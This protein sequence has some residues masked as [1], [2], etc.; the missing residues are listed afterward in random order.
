MSY[1]PQPQADR[2]R[3][4]IL[5]SR[6]GFALIDI[7][8]PGWDLVDLRA[9]MTVDTQQLRLLVV[10]KD[11]REA[12]LSELNEDVQRRVIEP[13]AELRRLHYR[14]DAGTWFSMR[15]SVREDSYSVAYDFHHEPP[16]EPPLE[17]QAYLR[18]FEAYRRDVM[19]LPV[20]LRDKLREAQPGGFAGTFATS[21]HMSVEDQREWADEAASLLSMNLP[22]GNHQTT[23]Y[24]H[25][26]GRHVDVSTGSLNFRMRK[27]PWEPPARLLEMF[28]ELRAGM[29]TEDAGTWF[30][31]RLQVQ[32]ISRISLDFNYKEE[33]KWDVAPPD[34]AYREELEL[35]PRAPEATP[36]W[37]AE[38]AGLAAGP[39][40]NVAKASDGTLPLPGYPNGYPTFA[41]RPELADEERDGLSAYLENAPVVLTEEGGDPDL[42]DRTGATRIP[43]EYRTDGSW[44]WPASVAYYLRTHSVAPQRGLVEHVRAQG[45][46]VPDVDQGARAAAAVAIRG[47]S[48]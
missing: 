29:Y 39:E 24:Y 42:F 13:M 8:P 12:A 18:D 21:G 48:A 41:D 4:E 26:L 16:W 14:P 32:Q 25:A 1:P 10:L 9:S 15:L 30:G 36:Y 19:H 31:A 3:K 27:V 23:I 38:R 2:E 22:P 46:R 33:P 47:G 5:E 11:G 40:L 7:A 17:P 6:I 45:F 43:R 37:L 20:W 35:F 44:V 28:E 34:G